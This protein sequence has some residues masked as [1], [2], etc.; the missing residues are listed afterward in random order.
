[1]SRKLIKAPAPYSGYVLRSDDGSNYLITDHCVTYANITEEEIDEAQAVAFD[2]TIQ[3]VVDNAELNMNEIVALDAL[4]DVKDE[5]QY[6]IENF[7]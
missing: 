6:A 1:M 3:G 7:E 4:P 2:I 5:I